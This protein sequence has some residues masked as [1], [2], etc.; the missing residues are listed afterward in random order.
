MLEILAR[1]NYLWANFEPLSVIEDYKKENAKS[2]V[3]DTHFGKCYWLDE[4]FESMI[5]PEDAPKV[6]ETKGFIPFD[7]DGFALQIPIRTGKTAH[8]RRR[9][10]YVSL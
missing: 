6:L 10:R 3:I 9:P 1:K 7:S 5:S 4:K 2:I 8:I